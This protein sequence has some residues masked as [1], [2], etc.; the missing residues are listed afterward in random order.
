MFDEKGSGRAAAVGRDGKPCKG[1]E[2]AMN[3]SAK[4]TRWLTICVTVILAAAPLLAAADA[5]ASTQPADEKPVAGNQIKRKP[6]KAAA[7]AAQVKAPATQSDKPATP[8]KAAKPQPAKA[9]LGGPRPAGPNVAHMALRGPVLS[10][11]P[12]FSLFAGQT[13]G[14]TLREWLQ[15]LAKARNDESIR[16]VALEI[17]SPQMSW[18]QAQELAD[19][20]ARLS[21]VK[22]V[23]AHLTA[24]DA[25]SYLVASA[26]RE[27]TLD[28]AGELMITGVATEMMFFRGTLDCIGVEPQLFQI[29]RYKGAAEPMTR[30]GP[31]EELKGE[32]GKIL[33]DLY[34]QLC[35]QIAKQ[36]KLTV[37][38][39]RNAVDNGPFSA[40]SARQYNLVDGLVER[41]AWKQHVVGKVTAKGAA[42]A[43]WHGNYG[44]KD[45]QKLD[46]GNPFA[47]FGLLMGA[48]A[49]PATKDPTVAIIHADGVIVDGQSG[50]GFFGGQMVGHRTMIRCF[51]QVAND[52][53]VKAVIFRI[54]S[55]G[56]SALASEMIYQAVRACATKK[57]VVASIVGVGGSGGYYIALGAQKIIADPAAITGSIGVVGGKLATTGLMEKLGIS[58]YEIARGQNAGLWT[59]RPWDERQQ[60]IVKDLMERTYRTFTSRVA[61]GRGSRVKD[62][63]KVAQGRVFTA[64]Q[65]VANGLIDEVGGLREALMAAQKAAGIESSNIIVLPRPKTLA[66]LLTG[67]GT[68]SAT[69]IGAEAAAIRTLL[70]QAPGILAAGRDD[71]QGVS[72][73]L[74]LGELLGRRC[75]LTAMPYHVSV[76]P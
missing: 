35:G 18:A 30:T 31:S 54:D 43:T 4:L 14:M 10:S 67:D 26:G 57:P 25:V 75:V 71:L 47:V 11:P 29:G 23:Y 2:P 51:E 5:P 40:Q 16:A 68:S 45:A 50:S 19:A 12:E 9:P 72:Y 7:S 13:Q 52:Y 73:L 49:E 37:P 70:A 64:R 46:L 22:P 74:T 63:E 28:P 39:V 32:Y 69:P 36:R 33:D 21:A 3:N 56:G 15:R 53:N 34:D 61:Q 38:H 17:D 48:K 8:D 44:A 24:G 27:L 58:T 55:P 1:E 6:A 42:S 41:A 59:S 60:K 62:I 20:V 66:D 76:K 65:A